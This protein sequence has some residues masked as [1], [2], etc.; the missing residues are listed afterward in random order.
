MA[1]ST[2]SSPSSTLSWRFMLT[3]SRTSMPKSCAARRLELG[4]EYRRVLL[5]FSGNLH[6]MAEFLQIIP[7]QIHLKI[8]RDLDHRAQSQRSLQM[9][10]QIDLGHRL[11]GVVKG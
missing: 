4:K 3:I 9:A 7:R 10:V 5:I 2:I 8:A 1:I 11:E 6:Q